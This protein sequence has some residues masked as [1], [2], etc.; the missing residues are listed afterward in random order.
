MKITSTYSVKLNNKDVSHVLKDTVT[1]YRGA[2]DFYINVINTEWNA[3]FVSIATQKAAVNTAERLTVS[4]A[5][6]PLV[7]YD[8]GKDFYK[9]PS[10]LR[11][12]A[13]AEAYGKVSSYR[14]NLTNWEKSDP[15]T[16]GM[17]PG[18]RF[19]YVRHEPEEPEI[20]EEF[21]R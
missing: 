15:R 20:D 1:V 5:K 19:Q 11:R 16:R 8:F 21:E 10:Y 14:S 3:A 13:I 4:T 9:F 7:Q 6:R 2:V 17:E 12:A 18:R